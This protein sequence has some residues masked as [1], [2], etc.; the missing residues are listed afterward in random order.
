MSK[1]AWRMIIYMLLGTVC[2]LI[3]YA[4]NAPLLGGLL[5]IAGALAAELCFWN[6]LIR[7]LFGKLRHRQ[8]Q[9]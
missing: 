7:Y 2:F 5:F 9:R 8:P 3:A 1:V 4:F 6:N